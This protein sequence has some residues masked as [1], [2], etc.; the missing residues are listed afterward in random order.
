[1]K[2]KYW[3]L[4]GL[5]V[6]VAAALLFIFRIN[7]DRVTV[8]RMIDFEQAESNSQYVWKDRGAIRTFEYAFRFGKKQEGK[9]DIAAP[10]YSVYLGKQRYWLWISEKNEPGNFMKP[11]DS[12]TLYR[13]SSK[14]TNKIQQ[15]LKQAYPHFGTE[16]PGGNRDERSINLDAAM[17]EDGMQPDVPSMSPSPSPGEFAS[18]A[19]V[20]SPT[21]APVPSSPADGTYTPAYLDSSAF[22][23]DEQAL[24][25]LINLRIKVIHER[26][27]ENYSQLFTESRRKAYEDVESYTG[28]TV[29][30]IRLDGDIS[31]KEQRSLYEAV[32]RVVAARDNG[33]ESTTVYVFQKGKEDGAEWRI[34]D[35]D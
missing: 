4:I 21:L 14:S 25:K 10:P 8:M 28:Y 32:A 3:F 19:I 34:A 15:L 9:V 35:V 16:M 2:R 18:P 30:S 26:D 24:I 5:A 7:G 23:G 29:T 31:I 1:M 11:E 17:L 13:L 12:G 20:E 33:D 22:A 27:W 6:V